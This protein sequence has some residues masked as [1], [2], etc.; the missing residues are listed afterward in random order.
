[1]NVVIIS[2]FGLKVKRFFW[3]WIILEY[4]KYKSDLIVLILLMDFARKTLKI[5]QYSNFALQ[6]NSYGFRQ[7]YMERNT[8]VCDW[9]EKLVSEE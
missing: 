7:N 5:G 4:V 8:F 6:R 1:M 3:K 2:L 9:I